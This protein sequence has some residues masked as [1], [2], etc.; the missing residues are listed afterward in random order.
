MSA[1]P[2]SNGPQNGPSMPLGFLMAG[3]EMASFAIFGLVLDYFLG[4][5]PGFTIGLTLLG[6]AVSFFHL[7]QMAKKVT[8]KTKP[9]E[10]T[11]GTSGSGS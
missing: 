11:D 2:S 1:D 8:A 3:S 5:M 6:V 4:T 10:P 9:T 7:I